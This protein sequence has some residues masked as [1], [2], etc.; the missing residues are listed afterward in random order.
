MSNLA[1]FNN[2]SGSLFLILKVNVILAY[3]IFILGFEY[4]NWGF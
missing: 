1:F 4:E 3:V 2:F